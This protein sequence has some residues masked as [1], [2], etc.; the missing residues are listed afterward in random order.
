M[1]GGDSGGAV[2]YNQFCKMSL[3]TRCSLRPIGQ[4]CS[5]FLDVPAK[6][7]AGE[8]KGETKRQGRRLLPKQDK[9]A[10]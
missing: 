2:T 5:F 10:S 3:K 9:K 4:E 6:Q 7:G 1:Y 8:G